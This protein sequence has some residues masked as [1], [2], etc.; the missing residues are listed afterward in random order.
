[1]VKGAL[2]VFPE[3]VQVRHTWRVQVRHTWGEPGPGAHGFSVDADPAGP[4][5]QVAAEV[6]R[7]FDEK[8]PV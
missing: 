4:A 3:R 6:Q 8:Y 5:D 2:T 7:L 1:M